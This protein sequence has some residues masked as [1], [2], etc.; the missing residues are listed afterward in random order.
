MLRGIAISSVLFTAFLVLACVSDATPDEKEKMCENLVKLQGN[1]KIITVADAISVI[2]TEYNQKEKEI[3][4][5][6]TE[7]IKTL[8]Q[9]HEQY[10][11]DAKSA[12]EKETIQKEMEAQKEL[13]NANYAEKMKRMTPEREN[14][15]QDVKYKA[16][17]MRDDYKNSIKKCIN[18]LALFGVDQEL[19]Q[20]RARAKTVDEFWKNCK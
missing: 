6:Q 13:I 4:E 8:E 5:Q 10:L 15:I 7:E 19:A 2:T 3:K 18:D 11:A 14:A 17:R 9:Q 12:K 20:C 16:D 1:A